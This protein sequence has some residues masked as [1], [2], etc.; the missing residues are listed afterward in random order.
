MIWATLTTISTLAT[1]FGFAHQ[2]YRHKEKPFTYSLLAIALLFAVLSTLL[3]QKNGELEAENTRLQNAK[4]EAVALYDSWP[5]VDRFDFVSDGEFQGIIISGLAFLEANRGAFP[6]NYID[7]KNSFQEK[8]KLASNDANYI[9]KRSTLRE[10][11]QAMASTVKS[12][13]LS[14]SR[15]KQ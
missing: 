15:R 11:A 7:A 5:S 13:R 9:S 4:L 12:L 8:L 2:L 10:A 3:W 14:D 1:L 6:E